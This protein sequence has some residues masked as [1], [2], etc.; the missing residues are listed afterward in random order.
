[1]NLPHPKSFGFSLFDR[2]FNYI[3]SL[4]P[5]DRFI[6][7]FLALLF[8]VMAVY[9]LYSYGRGFLVEVPVGGGTLI[10]GAVGAPRFINPVLAI[11]RA[12]HDLMTLTYSGLMRLSPDGNLE[13][14]LAESVTVA[15][16]GR[17]YNIVLS[18][19]RYFH[20]GVKVT[21]EDVA[22]TIGLIQ[23]ASLKS[24]IRGNWSGVTV[25]VIGSHELNLVLQ[26][27]YMPFMENLTLGILPKHIWQTLTD[28]EVPFS[29][30]NIEP[31]GSGPYKVS[32]ITRSPSGLVSE[33]QLIRSND[34]Q[35]AAHIERIIM[36]YYQNE[37]AVTTALREGE[38]TSTAAL[39]EHWLSTLDK[40]QYTFTSEPLPRVFS[41]FFNQ[42][43]TPVLRDL[44]VRKALDVAVDREELVRRSVA[45]FGHAAV[46]PL[47]ANWMGL[48]IANQDE[49]S[50]DRM[51]EAT[52]ILV[53]GGWTKDQNG[54]WEKQIDGANVP[55]VF[56]IRSA[57]GELFEKMAAYL[58]ETWQTLGAEV[59]FEFYEQGDLVQTIIR[60]RD[61]QAL[62]FGMDIGRSL[63]LYPFWHSSSR[64]DPGLN[65][66]L[67]ANIT[68]DRLVNEMRTAT[69]TTGR[70]Q[71]IDQFVTE[72]E[73]E[74]PA[75]FLFTPSFDY[76]T[77]KN[78]T[79]PG[80]KRLQRQ[81]E[82]FSNIHEWYMNESGVWPIFSDQNN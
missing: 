32:N 57:N 38:I 50:T 69:S 34:Y 27:P 24:P 43:R 67:Y 68:V 77:T 56:T 45:G 55:L 61:Y 15:D 70:D 79:T 4:R 36:R 44:A 7:A 47:P 37:E 75:I 64:E 2:L 63:D 54:R 52:A 28:E 58:S 31:I 41:I 72:I 62:L 48:E 13:N 80:F 65:V 3:E 30:Y 21:A 42:N 11:T 17:V 53:D 81:S 18:N 19:D 39:S 33:Y 71:L 74:R 14:D 12:D 8:V 73:E 9:N 20:D 76:V 35:D 51:A 6:V 10:E 59:N 16:D 25:E 46:S 78:V 40:D 26:N 66:S 60:P 29:Q 1:M 22:F 5:L 82:R 49:A 23:K